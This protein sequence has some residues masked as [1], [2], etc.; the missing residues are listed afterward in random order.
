[1]KIAPYLL[2]ILII[3]SCTNRNKKLPEVPLFSS[4]TYNRLSTVQKKNFLDSLT[5]LTVNSAND[6]LNRDFLFH[7]SAEYYYLNLTD[8]SLQ[9]S[10]NVLK[11]AKE[12]RDTLSL[13]RANFYIAD[14]YEVTQ[15]DS[16][17]Y[18]YHQAEKF[19]S[20]QNQTEKV[21]QTLFKK[22]YLLFFEGNYLESEIQISKAL[23]LLKESDNHQLLY[24]CYVLIGYNFEKLEE[25]DSALYYFN[26]SK[27]EL[28]LLKKSTVDFEQMNNYTANY[29]INLANVYDKK[30]A[31]DRSVLK[32][33]SVKN[34]SLKKGWPNDYASVIG[35]LGY[36]KMQLGQLDAAFGLFIESLALSRKRGQQN[37]VM[38]QL[39]NLGRYYIKVSDTTRAILYLREASQVAEKLHST[40]EI[41][42]TLTL[43]STIDREHSVQYN[44]RYIT[45]SD[46]LTKVQRTNRNKFARIEYETSV[47]EDRNRL[48][49]NERFYLVVISSF[50]LLTLLAFIV[51]RYFKNQKLALEYRVQK[52]MAEEEIF[53]LLKAHQIQ[54]Q[55]ARTLEQNRISRELHDGVMNKIYGIRLQ[56][57]MLN[58]G[59]DSETK[60]KRLIYVDL[61]QALEAEIRSISHDLHS[62]TVEHT[63]DYKGLLSLLVVKQNELDGANYELICDDAIDWEQMTGLIKINFYR[64]IQ[65]AL[66]NVSK[67]ACANN[68]KVT[69]SLKN[70]LLQL[71][72]VDDGKGFDISA[73]KEAGIGL[74]NIKARATLMKGKFTI[75]SSIG[76]GTRLDLVVGI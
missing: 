67:Y 24:S 50:L 42:K 65:E 26:L 12:Q 69:I 35:N 2:L 33:E 36:S 54:L 16:A 51:Y 32:L 39:L 11:M 37:N 9:I 4:K 64:I 22:A 49:H 57:G 53:A 59:N 34:D 71:L 70:Q 31:Y 20:S 61:L 13:A 56:L 46:S 66:Q 14:C 76:G 23:Q 43:L 38:Y 75:D 10:R 55:E 7:L 47:L 27:I 52:Q 62:D 48:L 19:Y 44:Q 30:G 41:K 3:G 63:F 28:D 8:K 29:S 60:K 58:D 21:G 74:K 25:Y 18:Y 40:D 17:Y 72:I 68:V 6:S 5:Q 73:V 15:K 45:L 1:M